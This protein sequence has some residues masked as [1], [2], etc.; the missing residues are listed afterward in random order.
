MGSR[1][2]R[3]SAGMLVLSG[4][5]NLDKERSQSLYPHMK[6]MGCDEIAALAS[7]KLNLVINIAQTKEALNIWQH[8]QLGPTHRT[9]SAPE[10]YRAAGLQRG[11]LRRRV[12]AAGLTR[13]AA[14]PQVYI[15]AETTEASPNGDRKITV[16]VSED[17]VVLE[18]S[19]KRGRLLDTRPVLRRRRRC[20]SSHSTAATATRCSH[21]SVA[22]ALLCAR[23]GCSLALVAPNCRS[24]A[25]RPTFQNALAQRAG[26]W[27]RAARR[28]SPCWSSRST[29]RRM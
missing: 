13:T 17:V 25:R 12:R 23:A 26:C 24:R 8:S 11:I 16:R 5:W 9:V 6:A 2:S 20:L 10:L 21:C 1:R 29:A 18:T 15:G 14:T 3:G 4:K 27:S 7:E 19:F 22:A 28:C